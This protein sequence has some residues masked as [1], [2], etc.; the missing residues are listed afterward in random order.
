MTINAQGLNDLYDFKLK[1]PSV[2]LSRYLAQT[3]PYFQRTI[4]TGLKSIAEERGHGPISVFG[5][6]QF[7]NN[8][9]T[10]SLDKDSMVYCNMDPEALLLRLKQLRVKAGLDKGHPEKSEIIPTSPVKD[11]MEISMISP[12]VPSGDGPVADARLTNKRKMS[13]HDLADLKKRFEALKRP[14]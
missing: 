14:N 1:Y 7:N 11:D 3:T 2:D 4:E 6:N 10:S 12:L 9:A 8:G 5:A 13:A